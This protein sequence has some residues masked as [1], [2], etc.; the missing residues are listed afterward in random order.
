MAPIA[1]VNGQV[2]LA[3]WRENASSLGQYF[4]AS[5]PT[6]GT[7][8]QAGLV[9][10]F[11]ATADGLFTIANTNSPN[12]GKTIQVDYIALNMTG[13]A[14]T[15]TTV[16]KM[17]VFLESGIVAPSAGNVT[18]A[19]SRNTLPNGPTSG[20][21]IN[22][23][24]GGAMMTLPAA[25]GTRT[26][27]ANVSLATS[28]GITGDTYIYEFGADAQII[29]GS[30]AVRATA[31]AQ[32]VASCPPLTIPPQYTALISLWWLTQATTG[33]TYEPTIAYT[34]S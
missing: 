19:A 22:G 10:A 24:T 23:F 16:Q 18:Y 5:N 15:A 12:G 13:T 29:G 17:A 8:I 9:T 31:A 1:V 6:P 28:L 11:S 34:E 26:L 30:T 27:V 14:P 3:A 32:L 33:A 20:A 2:N 25:V 21:V 4:I 7:G